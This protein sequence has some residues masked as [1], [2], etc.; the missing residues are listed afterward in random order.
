[1]AKAE[2]IALWM[3]SQ[4]SA[5]GARGFVVGLSGGVDSA[6]VARLAQMAAPGAVIAALLP[7]HNDARD[8]NDALEIATQYSLPTV[9]IDLAPVYDVFITQGERALQIV[10]ESGRSGASA[11]AAS[12]SAANVKPRLRMTALYFIANSWNYLVAGT[13]NR[14][15]LAVGYFTKY[16]DGGADLLPIGHLLKREVY[17]LARELRV[18]PAVIDRPP[19]ASL[20]LGQTDEEEMG[21]SYAE[22]ERYLEEGPQAV[23]PAL[24][25][26]I[27]RLMRQSEH[28]R[29]LPPVPEP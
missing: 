19:S 20:W 6:V 21:F 9:R 5:A 13:G 23:S 27:E 25:M 22:L 2:R 15:E 24:A 18:P 29:G 12:M 14:S 11:P 8:E 28:K 4:L 26:R 3:R 1:M 7:C 16:G 17:E 10:A